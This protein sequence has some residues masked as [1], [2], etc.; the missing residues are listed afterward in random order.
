MIG[1]I[2]TVGAPPDPR[3]AHGRRSA[4][5]AA[6]RWG[7]LGLALGAGPAQAA[8]PLREPTVD[9]RVDV[10]VGVASQWGFGRTAAAWGPALAERLE[11]SGEA[12]RRTRTAVGFTLVH[13]RPELVDLGA[14][15]PVTGVP[16]AAASGYRDELSLLFT[17][18]VPMDVGGNVPALRPVL[19][20]LPTF[21]FAA[22][23]MATD[24][25]LT[26]PG[27]EAAVP[28]RSRAVAPLLGAR[29]GAELRV[30]GWL[31][32][33]PHAEILATVVK[34]PYELREGEEWDA[35]ARV[36]AGA[37]LLVRF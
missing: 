5:P 14:L 30:Y 36:L 1:R 37:D 3:R 24:A 28:V 18:R 29:L 26:L 27:Y 11:L 31:S 12:G 7:A 19:R 32:L 17:V 33:L 16:A 15:V 22:G 35:E 13:A 4:R 8:E 10:A 25:H 34:D 9:R 2:P 6:L 23:V 20:V 21:A